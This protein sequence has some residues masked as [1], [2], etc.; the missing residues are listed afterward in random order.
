MFPILDDYLEV[1]DVGSGMLVGNTGNMTIVY[2]YSI[3][4]TS[5]GLSYVRKIAIFFC[6][7]PFIEY[8]YF[9]WDGV[10][11]LGCIR[12]D[13]GLLA[14]LTMTFMLVS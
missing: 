7:V 1:G 13:K 12:T 10:L 9:T 2:L 11:S 14:P 5:A 6:A 3:F 4:Q 8:V